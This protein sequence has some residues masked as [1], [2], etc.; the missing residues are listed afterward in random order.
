[1]VLCSSRRCNSASARSGSE[2]PA[3]RAFQIATAKRS[4]ARL[5]LSTSSCGTARD[6]SA[7]CRT[8]PKRRQRSTSAGSNLA[9]LRAGAASGPT[10][11]STN[12]SNRFLRVLASSRSA[13]HMPDNCPC[14]CWTCMTFKPAASSWS[15]ATASCSIA[16]RVAT[17]AASSCALP[18]TPGPAPAASAP[19]AAATPGFGA[20]G[21]SSPE[22][23]CAA[24]EPQQGPEP[25]SGGQG[26]G[27]SGS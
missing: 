19:L 17:S 4:L 26:P 1:M 24:P 23:P 14:N 15:T 12:C 8:A 16:R 11:A 25:L 27:C 3:C 22:L 9:R 18:A 10:P 6:S 20:H 21:A 13:S 5:R 7:S 2:T